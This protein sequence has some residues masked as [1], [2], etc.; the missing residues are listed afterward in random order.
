MCCNGPGEAVHCHT[1]HRSNSLNID[2]QAKSQDLAPET[3]NAR[4][5]CSGQANK[6]TALCSNVQSPGSTTRNKGRDWSWMLALRFAFSFA[7]LALRIH[8]ALLR[9]GSSGLC[10]TKRAC[11]PYGSQLRLTVQDAVIIELS[12]CRTNY[13]PTCR[14]S[15]GTK[16]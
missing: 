11:T 7:A 16:G 4:F 9:S 12:A 13:F 14:V 2:M 6:A 3:L 15:W 8:L 1:P 10:C 5:L